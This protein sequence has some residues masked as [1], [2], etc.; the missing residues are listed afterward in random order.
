MVIAQNANVFTANANVDLVYSGLDFRYPYTYGYS[1]HL[2]DPYGNSIDTANY[3]SQ[4][5][6]AGLTGGRGSMERYDVT[7]GDNRTNWTTW[8][9]TYLPKTS[10]MPLDRSGNVV[11][12]TPGQPNWTLN[13]PPTPAPTATRYKTPTA[14]PPTPFAHMVI[15]EFLPR[16][17][18]DWNQDGSI[19]V[20]DEFIELKNL[21]PIAVNIQG[22][23]IDVLASGPATS[24]TLPAATLQPG[25]RILYFGSQ[26][27]LLQ[28]DSGATV[29]LWNSRGV[30]IDAR[31]YGPVANPDVSHCRIPDGYYWQDAC[32]PTPGT[33][34]SLTG[35]LP[36]APPALALKPPPCL[37]ADTVPQPFRDAECHASGANIFNR[38]YWDD[39]AGDSLFLV[40]DKFVKWHTWVQ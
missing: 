28:P 6:P 18:T 26:D 27:H 34:N 40:P 1:L 3:T 32:F 7:V 11:R 13:H 25:D 30:L 4:S 33:E 35:T 16:A 2:I 10:T 15:N 20:F 31:S 23:K 36:A 29:R 21:G 12:G 5:W 24:Y 17:G 8:A 37:L 22:W 39:Q 14:R 9:G 38:L 19:D